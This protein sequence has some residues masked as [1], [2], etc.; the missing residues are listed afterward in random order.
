MGQTSNQQAA[1]VEAALPAGPRPSVR[2]SSRAL[3]RAARRGDQ[4]AAE[5]LA[6]RHWDD[7]YQAAYLVTRDAS[8]AED[9]AQEAIVKALGSLGG[10]DR[11]R[12][13]APW[14][15]RIVVNRAIDLVRARERRGEVA[16]DAAQERA[17]LEGAPLNE[18]P[19]G[20]ALA[21]LDPESRAVVVLRL[22]FDYR[23]GETAAMLETT[24]GAVRTRL[25]RA[26][27][28]L[29]ERLTEEVER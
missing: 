19:V 18:S 8:G 4:D 13:F 5:E 12:A 22:L 21:A 11:R 29:R 7:A 14:L 20:H 9:V 2:T 24:P 27:R 10:F 23:A 6:R 28:E 16:I 25:H 3:V 15:H 1:V 26:L 17:V